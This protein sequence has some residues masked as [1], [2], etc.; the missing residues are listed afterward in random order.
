MESL[1]WRGPSSSVSMNS[2]ASASAPAR[3]RE[4]LSLTRTRATSAR[5]SAS[6]HSFLAVTRNSARRVS[7]TGSAAPRARTQSRSP[8]RGRLRRRLNRPLAKVGSMKRSTAKSLAF[9]VGQTDFRKRSIGVTNL[10][11]HRIITL[12]TGTI[13]ADG[14]EMVIKDETGL[15]GHP[16]EIHVRPGESENLNGN[17]AH[18]AIT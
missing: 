16:H 10:D 1:R 13:L 8:Q 14:F 3:I 2:F 9:A 7:K 6:A 15:A 12:P 5:N 11:A 17:N 4:R 18:I